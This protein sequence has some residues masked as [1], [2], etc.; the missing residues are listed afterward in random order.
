MWKCN[1]FRSLILLFSFIAF[2]SC[3]NNKQISQQINR[4]YGKKVIVPEENIV[5][6][7]NPMHIESP[8]CDGG[9]LKLVQL[10][11]STNCTKCYLRT[12]S[13]W[14]LYLNYEDN[15]QVRFFFYV[16]PNETTV[17][18]IKEHFLNS[19]LQHDIYVDTCGEFRRLNPFLPKEQI[20]HTILLDENDK[21]IF[22][23]NPILNQNIEILFRKIISN[24]SR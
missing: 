11:D 14:N 19:G 2:S 18:D 22:V 16:E 5:L 17:K 13:R 12:L 4:L 9:T 3:N 1:C 7:H 24:N 8:K 10:I 21:I 15:C 23:G 6:L 20:Y